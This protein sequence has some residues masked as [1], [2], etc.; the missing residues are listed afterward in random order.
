MSL[1]PYQHRFYAGITDAWAGGARNVIGTMATGGGKGTV[2]GHAVIQADCPARI[3]AHRGELV[4]QLSLVLNREGVPH[5]IDAPAPQIAE[6]CKLHHEEHGRSWYKPKSQIRVASVQTLASRGE[7]AAAAE[8][9]GIVVID[10]GHHVIHDTRWAKAVH[11]YANAR[12]LFLTAHAI[13]GDHKGLGKEGHGLADALVVGPSFRELI[14][15]GYLCDYRPIA[16][17]NTVD[18][19][20]VPLSANGD[21]NQKKLRAATLASKTIVGDVVGHYLKFAGGKLGITFCVSVEEATELQRA[22]TKA[23]VRAEIITGETPT[24]VRAK[25]MRKF[26]ERDILVLLSIDV[27]GEGVDV[28]AVEVVSMARATASFQVYAQQTGRGSRVSVG[29]E[30]SACWDA[31]GADARKAAIAASDKPKFILIDHVGNIEHHG[32]PCVPRRYYLDSKEARKKKAEGEV[33]IRICLNAECMLPYPRELDA[34]PQCG[35]PRPTPVARSAPEHV[36]GN[37]FELDPEVLAGM[38]EAAMRALDMPKLPVHAGPAA[39]AGCKARW[40]EKVDSQVALRD[41]MALWA[42][43]QR[44]ARGLNDGELMSAFWLRFGFTNLEAQCLTPVA[45][46]ELRERIQSVLDSNGVVRA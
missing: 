36:E 41:T 29:P 32:L 37:L 9:V 27:L 46:D 42:G 1:R 15:E 19:S 22:Y 6:I 5:G 7:D 39:V 11:M 23:D 34:C 26:R 16:G 3:I 4:A 10:E 33:Q 20:S 35:T 2:I 38:I 25:L 44:S 40:Q 17:R 43:W 8:R 30:W 13:R 28:P 14:D 12:G 45:A 18:L 31:I 24:H 21:Y